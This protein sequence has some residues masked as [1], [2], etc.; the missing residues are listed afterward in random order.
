MGETLAMARS[1][2]ACQAITLWLL[3]IYMRAMVSIDWISLK[4]GWLAGGLPLRQ[5]GPKF[6]QEARVGFVCR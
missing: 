2:S 5:H 6:E 4:L 3:H 1:L